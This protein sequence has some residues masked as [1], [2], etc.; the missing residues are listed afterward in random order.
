MARLV[1]SDLFLEHLG[2]DLDVGKLFS[3]AL[4]FD[5]QILALLLTLANLLLQHHASLD[6]DVVLGFK[7]LERRRSVAGLALKVI[8]CDLGIA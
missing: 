2:L 6:G 8:V 4:G 7:I 1:F 5:A 3:Q